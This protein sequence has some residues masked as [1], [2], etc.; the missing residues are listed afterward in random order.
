MID[1]LLDADKRLVE[2]W[3]EARCLG[4]SDYFDIVSSFM[5]VDSK[6]NVSILDVF[7]S[8]KENTN[9]T[10]NNKWCALE[11]LAYGLGEVA[12]KLGFIGKY[13]VTQERTLSNLFAIRAL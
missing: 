12:C 13:R 1:A 10:T 3:A 7:E 2:G 6:Y 11:S 8:V 5:D 4:R 9:L